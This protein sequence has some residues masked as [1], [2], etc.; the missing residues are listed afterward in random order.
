MDDVLIS[1]C[2]FSALH[3]DLAENDRLTMRSISAARPP[4]IGSAHPHLARI[5]HPAA[6]RLAH[7]KASPGVAAVLHQP[8]RAVSHAWC[9][10]PSVLRVHRFD[11]MR[12]LE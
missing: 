1:N 9:R 12:V 2:E 10:E 3:I 11:K 4:A 8:A 5:R 7:S 6:F